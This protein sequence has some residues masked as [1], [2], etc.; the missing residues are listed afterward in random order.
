M[1]LTFTTLLKMT[2]FFVMFQAVTCVPLNIPPRALLLN[3]YCGS[4]YGSNCVFGCQSGSVKGDGNVTRTCLETGQW[5]GNPIRCIGTR[6]T[7]NL[8]MYRRG[9]LRGWMP[10]SLYDFSYEKT[11]HSKRLKLS[12]ATHSFCADI[13]V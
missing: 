3:G 13:L 9:R 7:I 4:T 12:I 2:I 8:R 1:A 5:S 10:P 11:T 6:R